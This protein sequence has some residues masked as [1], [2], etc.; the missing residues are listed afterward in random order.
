MAR[1]K[2]IWA[3][4]FWFATPLL[5]ADATVDLPFA[6]HTAE[7]KSLTKEVQL[8][9]VIEAVNRSTVSAETSGRVMEVKFDIGD[10]VQAGSVL[11]RVTK[12]EQQSQFA[13]TE[14]QRNEAQARLQEAQDEY[15]RVKGVFERNLVAQSALDKARAD[16]KAAEQ[17]FQAAAARVKQAEEQLRYTVVKAP[18]TGVV[19]DRH[20]DLG[21]MVAPGKPVMTGLSLNKLRA[22]AQVPQS[23]MG[24][25]R[26]SKAV[27][28]IFSQYQDGQ[29]MH[30][31]VQSVRLQVAPQAD[32]R[33]HTFLVRAYLPENTKNLY[34]GMAS[35]MAIAT[36]EKQTLLVPEQAVVHRS[37]LTAVYVIKDKHVHL[38]QVRIGRRQG[39]QLEILAGLE[40]GEQ[41]A[42]DPIEAGIYL[43]EQNRKV[44]RDKET[45]AAS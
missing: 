9:A 6:I 35:K 17:R 15:E 26:A 42:L 44:Q 21:E 23:L 34:P 11:V 7:K 40:A 18:Y 12:A 24:D 43:K 8:D 3:L 37:E 1:Q 41:V 19:V 30:T 29:L 22:V 32:A 31:T 2:L 13:A 33:S 4:M 20:V 16:L 10:F 38:R 39:D 25:L 28:V 45:H 5:A 36:G 27:R 14:A